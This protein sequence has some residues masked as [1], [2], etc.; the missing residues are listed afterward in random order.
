MNLY[1]IGHTQTSAEG[2]FG[3]LRANGIRRLIDIRIHPSGQLVG[4]AR[5]GDFPY[6]LQ[7][8]ADGCQYT[9]LPIL[10]PTKELL[11]QYRADANWPRYV[12]A[13]EALMDERGIPAALAQE[14]FVARPACLLCA[15]A[16]P[17]QCHRRL[18]AER[19]AAHWPDLTIV[20]L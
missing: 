10:A 15:E 4:F 13:F 19:L 1:T 16:T 6:L 12:K 18:V 14:D 3:R 17:E 20:H 9:H 11:Q 8:L 2:F 5:K 7:E